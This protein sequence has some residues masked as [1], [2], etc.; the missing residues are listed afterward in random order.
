MEPGRA[1]LLELSDERDQWERLCATAYRDGYQAAETAHQDDYERG[2]VAGALARKRAQH[3]LVEMARL[4]VARWGPAGR[5]HFADPRAGDFTGGAEAIERVRQAWLRAG[6]SLGPGRG[7]VHLGGRV[8][9]GNP[10]GHRPCTPA[11]SASRPGWHRIEDAVAILETLPG[12]YA[13]T[14]AELR[15]EMATAAA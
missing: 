5:E 7:W 14:I 15:S 8:V 6:L 13:E 9:H 3:D 4:D 2:L 10:G 12:D 11:C 1:P